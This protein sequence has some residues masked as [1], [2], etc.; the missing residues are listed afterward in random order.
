MSAGAR[1]IMRV[2]WRNLRHKL[3]HHVKHRQRDV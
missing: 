2:T 1:C 3:K